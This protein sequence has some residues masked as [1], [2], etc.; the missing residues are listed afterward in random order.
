MLFCRPPGGALLEYEGAYILGP[1]SI[2]VML[3]RTVSGDVEPS[4]ESIA[5]L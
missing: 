1:G 4:L 5:A 3:E 2:T